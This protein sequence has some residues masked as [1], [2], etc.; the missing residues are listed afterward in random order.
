MSFESW[1]GGLP[2]PKYSDNP[3]KYKFRYV[4]PF[5]GGR[6]I[7]GGR[8]VGGRGEGAGWTPLNHYDDDD[9]VCVCSWSPSGVLMAARNPAKYIKDNKVVEV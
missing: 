2:H 7:G 5:S 6:G 8:G 3:L 4:T 9:D 1:C